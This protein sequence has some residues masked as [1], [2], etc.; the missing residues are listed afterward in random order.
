MTVAE[1]GRTVRA[2]EPAWKLGGPS[3]ISCPECYAPMEAI[4]LHEVHIDRCLQHGVWFDIGE[5][6]DILQKN[7]RLAPGETARQDQPSKGEKAAEGAAGIGAGI[8]EVL[9]TVFDIVT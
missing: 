2:T 7:G 4:T 6:T 9:G 8:L 1:V 5:I 3:K